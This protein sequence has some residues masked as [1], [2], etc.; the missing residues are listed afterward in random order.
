MSVSKQR[1]LCGQVVA[2]GGYLEKLSR[3][4]H[5]SIRCLDSFTVSLGT[6]AGSVDVW[7]LASVEWRQ[8]VGGSVA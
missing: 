5:R 3:P 8:H 6:L 7:A 2:L 1:G 4:P